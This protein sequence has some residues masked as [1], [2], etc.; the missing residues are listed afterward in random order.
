MTL[1]LKIK[2]PT[3]ANKPRKPSQGELFCRALPLGGLWFPLK[4]HRLQMGL[5]GRDHV[6]ACVGRDTWGYLATSPLGGIKFP[7]TPGLFTAPPALTNAHEKPP[8]SQ[9]LLDVLYGEELEEADH[10]T[11]DRASVLGNKQGGD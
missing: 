9:P 6:T 11:G 7:L 10:Y 5:L 3:P 4:Q 1:L 8:T 2:A